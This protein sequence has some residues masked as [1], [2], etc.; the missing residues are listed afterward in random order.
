MKIKQ[1]ISM[2]VVAVALATGAGTYF[3]KT[4]PV[5]AADK[6][7]VV[8]Q[9]GDKEF[10]RDDVVNLF[11]QMQLESK[12]ISKEQGYDLIIGQM[13]NE[14]LIEQAAKTA[15]DANDE[16]VAKRI[17]M[18]RKQ[19][20]SGVY[21]ER[22]MTKRVTDKMV[23]AEYDKFTKENAGK[24]EIHARHILVKTEDEA[25]A[26]I[27]ELDG[28]AKF[29]ELAARKSK[30][31]SAKQGGD[32]GYFA[33]GQMVPEFETAAKAL[34]KGAYSKTPVKT[35]FGWHIIKVEDSRDVKLPKLAEM[36][37]IIRNKLGQTE[38]QKLYKELN[39]TASVQRFT[40]DGQPIN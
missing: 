8:A 20:I 4:T 11:N 13:I 38:M 3:A 25:K 40:M 10:F 27:K 16:E 2:A 22:Q 6:G 15:V 31:P 36:D 24:K 33:E 19:I 35:Q 34:K 14:Y 39:E 12:G 17:E 23:K 5:F 37:A 18:A 29:A 32:L 7:P 21:L 26:I 1:Q 30:G 9:V 28:G